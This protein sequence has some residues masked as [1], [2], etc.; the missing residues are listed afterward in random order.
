MPNLDSVLGHHALH[1]T[2]LAAECDNDQHY[3][4]SFS[5]TLMSSMIMVLTWLVRLLQ[6]WPITQS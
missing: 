1:L 5:E 4:C 6:V 3:H 2:L